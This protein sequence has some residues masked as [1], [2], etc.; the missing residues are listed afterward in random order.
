MKRLLIAALGA[1]LAAAG[2]IGGY[3]QDVQA[4]SLQPNYVRPAPPSRATIPLGLVFGP[5][6]LPDEVQFAVPGGFPHAKLL[7]ARS[8]V[9]DHLR[10]AMTTFFD[11]VTVTTDQNQAPSGAVVGKVHFVEVGLALAPG[12][13]TV[14][15]TLE[16]SLAL[17]RSGETAPFYS[18]GERT[19]GTREAGGAWGTLDPAPPTQGA[20]E[21]SMRTLLKDMD[22][23]SIVALAAGANQP[24]VP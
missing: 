18:W 14:I 5:R 24:S 15:G 10:D 8:L 9:T 13:R 1:A 20:I 17:T 23:K 19:A 4:R 22:A 21:A 2:C 12:G 16:W 11:Q 6:Q 7:S 3:L